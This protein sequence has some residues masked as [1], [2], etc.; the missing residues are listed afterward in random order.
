MELRLSSTGLINKSGWTVTER[1]RP[2]VRVPVQARHVCLL[3]RRFRSFNTDVTRPYVRALEARRL[4]H[5][6]VGGAGF[7][8]R[9]EVEAV[10]NALS[11]IERPDDELA[12]FATL[13]GPLFALSDAQLLAYRERA[14]SLHPFKTTS[15]RLAGSVDEV[16]ETLGIL[17]DLHRGR[18]RRPIADTIGRLLAATRAHAGFANWSTGEQA[19]ANVA[20]LMDMA[21]KSERSGLISFRGL[22]TG[23]SI[24]R[25]E[26][27]PATRR[28]SKKEW[29][30]SGS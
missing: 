25:S 15:R 4:P 30:A 6:L 28:S 29:M 17:R 9:E 16:V 13:K 26:E 19:L 27:K 18:N 1:E 10:R 7:H 22:S 11:A 21:R 3:F 24:R 23:W 14:H 5:L 20:R 12:V 8:T 2:G